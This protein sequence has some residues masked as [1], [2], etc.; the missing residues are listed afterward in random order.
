MAAMRRVPRRP[1]RIS[2]AT[3]AMRSKP[4]KARCSSSKN[5]PPFRGRRHPALHPL[6]QGEADV[7]LQ[8]LQQPADGGLG[9]AQH[10]G[11][12]GHAA[13]QHGVA[14]GLQATLA[15]RTGHGRSMPHRSGEGGPTCPS[16]LQQPG[17][18]TG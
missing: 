3:E 16:C 10:G 6:E 2:A 13:G 7:G 18:S 4:T 5:R 14:E 17:T 11:R 8:L 9:P 15:R 12:A 1:C